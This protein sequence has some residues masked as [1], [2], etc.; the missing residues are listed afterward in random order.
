MKQTT[1][2]ITGASSGIG[3]AFARE[4]ASRG[5]DL[6][7]VARRKEKLE[8][9]ARKLLKKHS[10]HIE[11]IAA[12]FAKEENIEKVEKCLTEHN[13]TMLVNNAGFGVH[14][15]FTEINL[16]RHLDMIHVHVIAVTR[17]CRLVLPG[18]IAENKGTIINVSSIAAFN[19]V[20]KNLIYSATKN[21]IN[22]FSRALQKNLSDTDIKVQALC[23]GF[24]YTGFHDTEEYKQWNRSV[25]PEFMWMTADKVV[26]LSLKALKKNKLVV[27]TGFKNRLL[28][29]LLANRLIFTLITKFFK[30]LP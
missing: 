9:I 7:L 10:V 8:D 28:A 14:G 5:Y 13:I 24:T 16:S 1:A 18:M 27:V 3:E 20:S 30:K 12:D 4:L 22:F 17:L 21:Y 19:P 23:P 2:L 6:V 29:G 25:I 26:S 15:K 11:V